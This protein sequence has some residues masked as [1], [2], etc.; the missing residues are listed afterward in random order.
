[1]AVCDQTAVPEAN[2][3]VEREV[4]RIVTAGTLTD[5]GFLDEGKNN[6]LASV[7]YCDRKIGLSWCDLSTGEFLFN[8]FETDA[9]TRLSDALARIKPVEVICNGE[10]LFLSAD[11][12][13]V[14]SGAAPKFSVYYDWAFEYGEAEENFRG[15]ADPEAFYETLKSGAYQEKLNANNRLAWQELCFT[16]VPS[17]RMGGR[18]LMAVEN[19]GVNKNRLREFILEL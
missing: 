14:K 11:L 9:L 5:N 13:S 2:K 10:M 18:L 6:F 15:I 12:L 4:T 8:Q 16:A 19:V 1:V 7:F 17:Y 3:L